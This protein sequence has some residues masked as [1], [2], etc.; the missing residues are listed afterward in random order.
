MLT[1]CVYAYTIMCMSIEKEKKEGVIRKNITLEQEDLDI[2]EFFSRKGSTESGTI[3]MALRDYYE[4]F[5]LK[6]SSAIPGREEVE[7]IT[8]DE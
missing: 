1:V 4:K 6:A 7:T 2:L 5:A 8:I 3:R